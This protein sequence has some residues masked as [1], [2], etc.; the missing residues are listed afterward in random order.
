MKRYITAAASGGG[1]C[2]RGASRLTSGVVLGR[3]R[4]RPL[5]ARRESIFHLQRLAASLQRTR[6]LDKR[7]TCFT[8][9]KNGERV[10]VRMRVLQ[11][12]RGEFRRALQNGRPFP[13][14]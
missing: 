3:T 2:Q 12:V 7:C 6:G 11:H 14:F 1:G 5:T 9:P 13:V 8:P 10:E 4:E